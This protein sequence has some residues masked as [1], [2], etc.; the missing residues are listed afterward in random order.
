MEPWLT[1]LE[2]TKLTDVYSSGWIGS[3]GS[4]VLDF[5]KSLS[6]YLG[7]PALTVSN[8]S[9]ALVLALTALEIRHGDEVIVPDFTYA[10]AASSIIHVGATPVFI[11]INPRSWQ[12]DLNILRRSISPKTKAVIVPHSY[13]TASDIEGIIVFCR[14]NSIAVIE[15]TS[16]AFSGSIQGKKLGTFGDIGTFSFFAN[17]L[18][19]TGEGGAVTTNNLELLR[20]MKLLRGQGMD[21]NRRYWFLQPGFNFRLTSLQA[22]IGIIQL[23]RL[24]EIFAKRVEIEQTYMEYLNPWVEIPMSELDS[25]R[26]PWI[27]SATI[28]KTQHNAVWNIATELARAGIESRPLFFQL[29]AMP[30]F[31]KFRN[32]KNSISGAMFSR[33]I[34]LP[35]S[36]C[37]TGDNIKEISG[38]VRNILEF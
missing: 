2:L 24:P 38:I 10:A 6:E 20:K 37:L 22:A 12:I 18:I 4:A 8:G 9:V 14:T 33:G 25:I 28:K 34:S 30:A 3:Q 31:S 32:D 16:E 15:D 7:Q 29:S 21:T 11:D 13:G 27:F 26:A 5:E 36:H 19:T 17:K 35:S 23:Q 1:E